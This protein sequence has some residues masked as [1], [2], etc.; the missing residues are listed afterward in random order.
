MYE[1]LTWRAGQL[2]RPMVAEDLSMEELPWDQIPKQHSAPVTA[3]R[4]RRQ[5]ARTRLI[6]RFLRLQGILKDSQ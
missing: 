1:M 4:R 3:F 5:D 2:G 6:A